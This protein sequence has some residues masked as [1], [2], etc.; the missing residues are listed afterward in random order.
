MSSESQRKSTNSSQN[1]TNINTTLIPSPPS[2]P[3]LHSSS[4]PPTLFESFK[5]IFL[6]SWINVLLI[7]VPLGY[8]AFGLKWSNTS[9]F[10]I[11]FLAIIPLAKLLGFATEDISL[12][13]GQTIGGLLN[14]TFGNAVELIVSIIALK[15]GQIRVVQASILGSIISNLLLVLGMCF[16]AGGFYHKEQKFNMTAA[17]TS[18]SLMALACIGLIIPAAF[19]SSVE[20]P[21]IVQT[22]SDHTSELLNLSHGTAIVL[23]IIYILYLLFQLKTHTHLY[24]DEGVI[25]DDEQPQLT[26]IVSFLLLAAVTV[27]VAFSAEYLVGSI[28]GIVETSGLS[29]TFVGLILLPIVGNAAEHVTAVTVAM[30]NKM[31]LAINVAA[32]S[33]MQIALF[34]SPLLVILGWIIGQ[35]MTLFFRTFETIVLFISVLITNYL[36]QDGES[37]WLEAPKGYT[38]HAFCYVVQPIN[39]DK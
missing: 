21:E 1:N 35:Q 34:V 10:V 24:Q 38:T 25:E 12:R 5:I 19:I 32:G 16:V 31:D 23:L 15:E 2:S 14:A 11:N 26:L 17:Q 28:E 30:K 4:A 7:F 36:I 22:G 39:L 6:S 29:K 27:A 3:V 33:S 8:I 18:S 9:V 20:T 37:N 13:V